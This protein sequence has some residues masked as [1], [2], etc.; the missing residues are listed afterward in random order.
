M[1]PPMASSAMT[2]AEV[3]VSAKMPVSADM[4]FVSSVEVDMSANVVSGAAH[5]VPVATHVAGSA[6]VN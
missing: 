4:M 2:V 3:L 5:I 6:V 1:V